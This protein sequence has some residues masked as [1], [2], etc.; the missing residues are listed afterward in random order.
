MELETRATHRRSLATGLALPRGVH[1]QG[2]RRQDRHLGDHHPADQLRPVEE[3]PGD[4]VHL[5]RARTAPSCPRR[6]ARRRGS[7]RVA[8]LGFIVVQID[9]MGTSNRSKA[10]HDVAWKNIKD[11]GFPDRILWHRGRGREVP[12][13][14]HLAGSASTARRPAGRTP[15]ARSS[16]TRTSTRSPCPSAGCHDN[17]MDKIWWNEQWMGWPIGPQYAASSN[18]DNAWR[19]QGKLL[20]I[21]GEMDTNVDPVL[22]H[23]GGQRAHQGGQGLRLASCPGADHGPG[24]DYGEHKRNDFFVRTC[25]GW[26]RSN[27]TTGRWRTR[28]RWG[29]RGTGCDLRRIP[30]EG[31]LAHDVLPRDPHLD[32]RGHRVQAVRTRRETEDSRRSASA[33][34]SRCASTRRRGTRSCA[35]R[36][37]R[38]TGPVGAGM[39]Q[40]RQRRVD[41]LRRVLLDRPH[42]DDRARAHVERS[43]LEVHAP[44]DLAAALDALAGP[45]VVPR[46]LRQVEVA[47]AR[48]RLDDRSD[49]HVPTPE[50]LVATRGGERVVRVVDPERAHDREARVVRLAHRRVQVG[51]EAVA[52]LEV[53]PADRLD[54]RVVQLRDVRVAGPAPVAGDSSWPSSPVFQPQGRRRCQVRPCARNSGQKAPNWNQRTCSSPVYS[55]WGRSHR[56][57]CPSTECPK[58]GVDRHGNVRA[59]RLPCR[60]DV[61]RP[62]ERRA[63]VSNT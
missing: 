38:R 25:W 63:S 23:A 2:P 55:V 31:D 46:A 26:S 36:P 56:C 50:V 44:V 4:R 6:S 45:E 17:R 11:A 1:G 12:V 22:D 24:G 39:H 53:L 18:M 14:R 3:V 30:R 49:Q 28:R 61:A 51:H 48:V 42:G 54:L 16:S 52:Q 58:A 27:G 15:W 47:E 57:R 19:L 8:E 21:V 59:Q 29:G 60:V 34:A 33:H 5:R 10:F 37:R 9:G 7:R 32:R 20:L 40:E 62:E 43:R 13:V 35:R 41:L